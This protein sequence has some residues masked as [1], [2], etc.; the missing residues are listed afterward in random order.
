[1]NKNIERLLAGTDSVLPAG[2]L[3]AKLQKKDC[4]TIKLG[5]DP[6]APDLH[7]GHA[8]VLSK[9]REFQDQGHNVI[10]LIGDFTARIGDPSGKS[11]TRPPLT[12][13]AIEHNTKTYFEQVSK[14]LDPERFTVRYNSEWLSKLGFDDVLKLCAKTT[15]A[16]IIERNDFARRLKEQQ[17]IGMH[18]LLYPIMQGY[19]SVALDADV[20]LGGTDQTFNLMMGRFLQEQ[21]GKDAQV[22]M[23]MPILEGLDGVQKM[24]KSLGNYIGI[25]EPADQAYG[26]L[27]SISDVLMWR[28]LHLLVQLSESEI[29]A[30]QKDV[31]SGKK[32]PMALKK[33]MAHAVVTRFWSSEGADKA[34]AAFE[35]LFEKKDFSNVENVNLPADYANPVWIV[36]LLR[37]LKAVESSSQARRLIESGA[38]SLDDQKMTDFKAEVTWKPGMLIKVGKHRFYKIG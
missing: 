32:H 29:A 35:Q 8:L 25:S 36:N 2:E 27:M 22:V 6:T 38:V 3:E 21:Y 12:Q 23:T 11:K 18:E 19:D 14:I 20:E 13:E 17:A 16:R 33:E 1:M 9:M 15:V 7:L 5:M 31:I 24:S 30:L 37:T 28:Y 4:L 34:Q 10:F 26:K